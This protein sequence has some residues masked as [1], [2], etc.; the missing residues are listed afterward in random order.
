MA[1]L[2]ELSIWDLINELKSRGVITDLLWNRDDVI[3]NLER[4]NEDR[5]DHEKLRDL[6][7]ME[8]DDILESLTF[9]YYTERINEEISD[10]I[11]EY[12]E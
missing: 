5:E 7:E 8:M 9:G 10:A 11:L 3:M 12:L 2:K 4:I 6:D 1:N